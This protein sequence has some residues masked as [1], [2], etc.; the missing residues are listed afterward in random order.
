MSKGK[1]C[2]FNISVSL[3]S[4]VRLAGEGD[5]K[6]LLGIDKI[7]ARLNPLLRQPVVPTDAIAP[8]GKIKKR[9]RDFMLKHGT[10]D[11]LLN[12]VTDPSK[13]SLITEKVTEFQNDFYAAKAEFIGKYDDLCQEHL[14]QVAQECRDEGFERCD[15][16]VEVIRKAQPTVE[17]LEEQ[18]Q[19]RFLKPKLI[20]LDPDEEQEVQEG[21]Y[22]RALQEVAQRSK[23]A[24]KA[25]LPTTQLRAVEE[26]AGKFESLVYLDPRYERVVRELKDAVK[27]IPVKKNEDYSVGERLQLKGVFSVLLDTEELDS[28]IKANEGLFPVGGDLTPRDSG[29]EEEAPAESE[30]EQTDKVVAIKSEGEE[31][32]EEQSTAQTETEPEVVY[33]W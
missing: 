4:P 10:K 3:F 11:E 19:F 18:I 13:K 15:E 31:K 16:L 27:E 30:Q 12:W 23:S 33:A 17:Y 6:E 29:E 28:R 24:I 32:A 20:E 9:A 22:W 26:V 21:L 7:P 5:L 25:T 14:E 8:L 2:A 1:V